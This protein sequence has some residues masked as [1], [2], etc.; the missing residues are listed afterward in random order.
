[1]SASQRFLIF[2]REE[3]IYLTGPE[4]DRER[5]EVLLDLLRATHFAVA[6][7]APSP[8]SLF[9][10]PGG[11][12]LV[13]NLPEDSDG[14]WVDRVQPE[15]PRWRFFVPA[16]SFP[17]VSPVPKDLGSTRLRK[18][19]LDEALAWGEGEVM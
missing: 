19:S 1:M 12:I 13:E 6:S 14:T 17:M 10:A 2:D 7:K 15:G 5:G 4:H 11:K 18:I 8:A 16:N 3:P 9:I